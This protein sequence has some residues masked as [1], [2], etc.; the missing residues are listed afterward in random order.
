MVAHY[1]W[2]A[3]IWEAMD[4][5]VFNSDSSISTRPGSSN[6]YD[7]GRLSSRNSSS[8]CGSRALPASPTAVRGQRS[9][10]DQRYETDPFL[11]LQSV[12]LPPMASNDNNCHYLLVSPRGGSHADHEHFAA[13]TAER[14]RRS[15][16][17][18]R[19]LQQ[20]E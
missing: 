14:L 8:A 3:G 11:R 1:T 6:P 16:N 2:L 9:S 12:D 13:G 18:R 4:G 10:S 15:T 5:E 7:L 17:R 19:S 20:R